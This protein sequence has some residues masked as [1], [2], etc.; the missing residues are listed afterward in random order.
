MPQ[1]AFTAHTWAVKRCYHLAPKVSSHGGMGVDLCCAPQ[2]YKEQQHL[3][4]LEDP[5]LLLPLTRVSLLSAG[6]AGKAA[7]THSHTGLKF[8]ADGLPSPH[9]V[10]QLPYNVC[11]LQKQQLLLFCTDKAGNSS[12]SHRDPLQ[13]PGGSGSAPKAG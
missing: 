4:F 1:T 3:Q 5:C 10:S 12:P 13:L 6:W 7:A 11:A 8:A 9:R 2:G